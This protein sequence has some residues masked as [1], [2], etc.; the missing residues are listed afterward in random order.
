MPN[1]ILATF[2]QRTPNLNLSIL[3]STGG[4]TWTIVGKNVYGG[5]APN[6]LRDPSIMKCKG[7]YYVVYTDLQVGGNAFGLASS[8]DLLNWTRMP[9]VASFSTPYNTSC[10][11]APEWF[12]DADGSI[13]VLYAGQEICTGGAYNAQIYE[14]H[15]L[16]DTFL[17]W[18]SPVH[19]PVNNAP[20]SLIDPF[21]VRCGMTY[22]LWYK[23]SNNGWIEYASSHSV[24]G[25][26]NVTQGGDW[27]GIGY[28]EGACLYQV[29]VTT[30][31]LLY[32]PMTSGLMQ[33]ESVDNWASWGPKNPITSPIPTSQGTAIIVP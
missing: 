13:H 27:M 26:Y 2:D 32:D 12:V 30:W 4:W 24:L 19:V 6:S 21:V 16:D 9:D 5:A 20:P 22:Y 23:N 7:K 11:M 8:P 28:G 3:T 33:V 15:P 18:S 25:P 29:G 1:Y 14:T 10:T 17:H 31:R